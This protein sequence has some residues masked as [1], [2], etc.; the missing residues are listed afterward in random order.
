VVVDP[1]PT[2]PWRRVR[3]RALELWDRA[4]RPAGRGG[5]SA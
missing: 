3:Y 1:E 5:E 2:N 4:I